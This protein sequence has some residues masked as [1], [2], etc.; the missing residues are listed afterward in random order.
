MDGRNNMP[1]GKNR[2]LARAE[3]LSLTACLSRLPCWLPLRAFHCTRPAIP[4]PMPL[5]PL[6]AAWV[7]CTPL[8]APFSFILTHA[9]VGRRE[10]RRLWRG[11][12]MAPS[13]WSLMDIAIPRRRRGF[14]SCAPPYLFPSPLLTYLLPL[15]CLGL[16]CLLIVCWEDH[17]GSGWVRARQRTRH[18]HTPAALAL[19]R[20]RL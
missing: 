8:W 2:T 5:P 13:A 15:S 19:V 11:E 7:L 9:A 17:S 14:L 6:H 18:T 12:N 3:P 4:L 20:R 16:I 10:H 1:Y